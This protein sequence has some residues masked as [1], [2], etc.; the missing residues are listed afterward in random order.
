MISGKAQDNILLES[1]QDLEHSQSKQLGQKEE[2]F[3]L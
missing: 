1:M 2:F 3:L